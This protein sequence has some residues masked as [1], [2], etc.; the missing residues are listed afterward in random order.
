VNDVGRVYLAGGHVYCGRRRDD[1]D[2]AQCLGCASLKELDQNS[3]PPFVVCDAAQGTADPFY[4]SW[5]YQHHRRSR[6]T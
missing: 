1:C 6:T 5:W 3:S 2:I 4:I